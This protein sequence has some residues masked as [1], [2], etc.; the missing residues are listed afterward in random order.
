[1]SYKL[2]FVQVF[3]MPNAKEYLSI[4]KQFAAFEVKYPEFP[5]G[6]RYLPLS[7][8]ESA[9]TLIWECDF[10]TLEELFKTQVFLMNDSRHED[11]FQEQSKYIV[12][13]YTEVYRPF[14][15]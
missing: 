9:N 10:G 5:K 6:K 2:R 4:E 11:L 13:A 1:M 14:E 7:G 15:G 8:R 12:S 3:K